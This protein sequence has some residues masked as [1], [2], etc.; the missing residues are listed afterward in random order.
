MTKK[1]VG[2]TLVKQAAIL[3][4]AS[5]I[6]RIMGLIYRWPL[7]NMIGDDG[8]GL[9]GTAFNIYLLFFIL[10][11]AGL[12]SAIS[13]MVSERLALKQYKSAHKVFRASLLM[14][15]AAGLSVSLIL[16]FAAY[17]IAQFMNNERIVYCMKAL[18]PTLFIVAVMGAFRGY[19]QGM[20]TMVPTAISQI[21]EQLFNAVFS[22]VLAGVLLEYGVEYAAAGGTMG[23]GIGALIG[24]VFLIFIYIL[25]RP[26][27]LKRVNKQN[28]V[29]INE[30]FSEI[31]KTLLKISVPI[32]IGSTIFSLTNL[33]DVKMVM[34]ILQSIGMT[35]IEANELYGQL[36]G[37]YVTLTNLPISISTALAAA[38]V[39]SIAASMALKEKKVVVNKV[40]LAM[41]VTMILAAPSTVGLFVLGDPVLKMLFPK[42]PAGGDLLRL[43]ALAII[44][45]SLVQV[46]TAILQGVGRPSIPA[47]NAGAGVVIKIIVNFFLI[48]IPSINIKGAVI[49]TLVCYIIIAYL[50]MRS[51]VRITKVR[52]QV[53]NTFIKPIAAGIG[54]GIFSFL[55]YKIILWGTVNNTF[56]TLSS[57]ILSVLV[58]CSILFTI[59]GITREEIILLP[60][61]EKLAAKLIKLG[62]IKE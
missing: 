38:I 11:S 50:D 14:A 53:I 4:A 49:S 10:S 51:A 29:E 57:I 31:F 33:I 17:P 54:M 8:N 26:R 45:Q 36:T 23:T 34:S 20:N 24:L 27:I 25:V 28:E 32:I 62:I 39:P 15:I 37:K 60:R 43:G 56:A 19:Y 35:E 2:G 16:W 59:G 6:V 40:N 21:I 13:K 42:Y 7:T 47:L 9:Y 55:F 18:A 48:S 46:A 22:I 5:L 12:P 30:S 1:N 61:G 41:R 52:I 44:F 58:Y 3:A